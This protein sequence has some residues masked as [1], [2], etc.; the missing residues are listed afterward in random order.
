MAPYQ[1][2]RFAPGDHGGTHDPAPA[3]R[4]SGESDARRQSTAS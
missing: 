1:R 4:R 2:Q 3:T